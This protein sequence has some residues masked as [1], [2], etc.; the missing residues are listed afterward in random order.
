MGSGLGQRPL[1]E[2]SP[3]AQRR[4]SPIWNQSNTVS[5]IRNPLLHGEDRSIGKLTHYGQAIKHE[6]SPHDAPASPRLFWKGRESGSPFQKNT[7]NQAPYDPDSTFSPSRRASLENL[8]R[9]SRVRNSN[10][11]RDYK[12]EYDPAT[13]YVPQR[14]LA[15]RRSP[16]RQ[17]QTGASPQKPNPQEDTLAGPRPPSPS[18]DQSA[19]AKSSLSRASRFGA[20]DWGFDPESE[21]WSELDRHPK[22]VTFD[23][24]PPQVN[25]Y[26]MTTPDPSSVASDSRDG[27]YDTED[28]EGDISF[29]RD[30]SF[31]RDDSF[32]ASLEDLEKTPV[33]LPEDWRY[34]SPSNMN[35]ALVKEEEDPFTE[36]EENHSPDPRPSSAQGLSRRHSRVESL[37]S[38]GERRPLPPLPNGTPQPAAQRPTSPGKLTAAFERG[39]AGQRVLPSPPAAA[40]YTKSDITGRNYA[41]MPLEER[42]RLMMI[43]EKERASVDSDRTR[44]E[45]PCPRATE[46]EETSDVETPKEKSEEESLAPKDPQDQPEG[47]SAPHISRDSILR[48][49]RKSESYLD[50]P[51]EDSSQPG[52]SPRPMGYDPDYPIPSLEHD[53][54]YD[55]DDDTDDDTGSVVIK[56]E[57]NDDDLYDVPEYD[58]IMPPKDLSFKSLPEKSDDQSHYSSHSS[59]AAD[60]EKHAESPPDEGQTTP[61][62]ADQAKPELT[63]NVSEQTQDNPQAHK[64]TPPQMEPLTTSLQRP[65]TPEV[66]S[67]VSAPSSPDSVIR[68]SIDDD[69]SDSEISVDDDVPPPIATVKAHGA[70]LK[71]RPS[72]TPLDLQTMAATRRQVS[73]QGPPPVPSL[74]KQLS[75]EQEPEQASEDGQPEDPSPPQL[76]VDVAQRQSSLM[77]LD[78]PFSIQEESLGFGLDKEFDR[79]IETQKVAFELSLSQLYRRV[80]IGPQDALAHHKEQNANRHIPKQK[81]YLTRHNTKVVIASSSNDD[82][83]PQ[84]P[85]QAPADARNPRSAGPAQR[86]PSQQ[87]WTTVPWNSGPRRASIRTPSSA[88]RKKPVSGPAPPLPGQQSNVQDAPATIEETEPALSGV[89]EEGEERGRLFVKVVGMKYL[90]LPIPRGKI[91][92][93]QPRRTLFAHLLNRRAVVLFAHA[94]QRYSLCDHGL[95]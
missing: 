8:K 74:H 10:M 43:Q 9:Q 5:A 92:R 44:T 25:E 80:P 20:K 6:P 52:S 82:G 93:F 69:I 56:H 58:G 3:M 49:L 32:D 86:K 28:D 89:L 45:E 63:H 88:I 68:H 94:G 30:S 21:I 66:D 36:D 57:E 79:V 14:P 1:S 62:P 67:P 76:G 70:G 84:T 60:A 77:K 48:D 46:D 85:G 12:Q 33:V 71:T 95:A 16:E 2:V 64:Q 7:E 40:S 59:L 29:D 41:S 72:L 38:N 73:G 61:I 18:K 27:S 81:G 55:D 22:S 75:N 19:P 23:A 34:M 87:T 39:T 65:A 13:V 37:D 54:M 15:P 51:Y 47:F 35:E 31:D 4:N 83:V 91:T 17:S 50:D 42:L 26:V 11:L 53:D 90:D 24:A 78:I